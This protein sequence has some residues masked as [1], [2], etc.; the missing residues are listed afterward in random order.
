MIPSRLFFG[1]TNRAVDA[2]I[3]HIVFAEDRD[4][5]V[6]ATQALSRVPVVE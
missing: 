4:D 6:A 1:I 5:L 2:L 3:E